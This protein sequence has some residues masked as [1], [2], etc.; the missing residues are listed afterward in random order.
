ML[1]P[2]TPRRNSL[3]FPPV[4]APS[5]SSTRI[6]RT[7]TRSSRKLP[8]PPAS[9]PWP[10]TRDRPHFCADQSKRYHDPVRFLVDVSFDGPRL[11]AELLPHS[12]APLIRS[13]LKL[14]GGR[15]E[16]HDALGRRPH[17]FSR[18]THQMGRRITLSEDTGQP[19]I[20]PKANKYFRSGSLPLQ[21]SALLLQ[22]SD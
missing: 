10:T 6:P 17:R 15:N 9:K 5:R 1:A 16:P 14:H 18:T 8:P 22:L 19:A 20:L 3:S 2:G 4:T 11:A 7:P 13:M 12:A 21:E